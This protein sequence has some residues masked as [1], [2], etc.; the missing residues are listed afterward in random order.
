MFESPFS[1]LVKITI[2]ILSG[3]FIF[4]CGPKSDKIEQIWEGGI[5]VIINHPEPYKIEG[6]PS[7]LI[8]EEEFTIDTE[9]EE[10][11]KIG[12]IDI[13]GFTVDSE[14]NIYLFKHLRPPFR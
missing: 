2:I 14:E 10:I 5:E 8:L 9:N 4:S 7:K 11:A 6:E 3:I 1:G 13:W 12:L